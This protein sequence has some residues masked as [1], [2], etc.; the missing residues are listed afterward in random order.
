LLMRLRGLQARL[1]ESLSDRLDLV[2]ENLALRHQLM[3]CERGRRLRGADRLWWCVLSRFW[4]RWRDPLTLVQPATVLRWRR[5]AWRRH[6]RGQRRRQRGRPRIDAELQVL[7]QRMAAENRLWGS[8]RIK[9]ELRKLGLE[10]SNSTVRRYRAAVRR[11]P[12]RQSWATFL[13]N[14]GPYLREA[15]GEEVRERARGLLYRCSAPQRGLGWAPG[16]R[17]GRCRYQLSTLNRSRSDGAS[18]GVTALPVSGHLARREI[19]PISG[20]MRPERCGWSFGAPQ[21]LS[22]AR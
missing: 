16:Q 3:V 10:V 2:L 15:L 4:P 17:C 7:I 19:L 5:M 12:A 11:S 22:T 14:H 9:G 1:K 13:Q 21:T 18:G 6:L 8:V 20:E